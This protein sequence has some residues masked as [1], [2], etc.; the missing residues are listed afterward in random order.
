MA[1][2][3]HPHLIRNK[4]GN[5][6]RTSLGSN[7]VPLPQTSAA[8]LQSCWIAFSLEADDCLMSAF[9]FCSHP[10]STR[11]VQR[12][13]HKWTWKGPV[14]RRL[15]AFRRALPADFARLFLLLWTWRRPA[16]PSASPASCGW[17]EAPPGCQRSS[18][19]T[20]K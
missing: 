10:R 11:S 18:P 6:R 8:E 9:R 5:Q 16:A 7:Q 3:S 12:P 14:C 15:P 19:G 2:S 1:P 4:P 20:Q 13:V 17:P